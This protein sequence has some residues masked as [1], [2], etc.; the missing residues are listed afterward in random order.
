L[1][2]LNVQSRSNG[3]SQPILEAVAPRVETALLTQRGTWRHQLW[4][5]RLVRVEPAHSLLAWSKTMS[6][7]SGSASRTSTLV[8]RQA[9]HPTHEDAAGSQS[10]I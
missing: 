1:R 7:L 2:S 6:S 5:L 4:A 10:E 3:A 9:I 8:T